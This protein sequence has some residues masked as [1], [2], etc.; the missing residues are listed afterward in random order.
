MSWWPAAIFRVSADEYQQH[1]WWDGCLGWAVLVQEPCLLWKLST[2]L[3]LKRKR[4][5]KIERKKGWDLFLFCFFFFNYYLVLVLN[6]KQGLQKYLSFILSERV[7]L[8]K[9]TWFYFF[10]SFYFCFCLGNSLRF[11][12]SF[13]PFIFFLFVYLFCL[14]TKRLVTKCSHLPVSYKPWG[15]AVL[16]GTHSMPKV[17]QF[18]AESFLQGRASS[19]QKKSGKRQQWLQARLLLS[20]SFHV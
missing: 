6:C 5:K 4:G 8:K 3:K 11:F 16:L 9:F 13:P 7:F 10:I 20:V 12:F 1:W 2:L 15:W 14:L 17:T 19:G 18:S